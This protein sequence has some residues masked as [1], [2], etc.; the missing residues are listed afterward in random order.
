[1]CTAHLVV[2][3]SWLA[4]SLADMRDGELD[5]SVRLVEHRAVWE[6]EARELA[7]EISRVLGPETKVEHIGST[8][9]PGLPAKPVIDLLVGAS[10]DSLRIV[11]SRLESA[12]WQWL[13]EAGIPGRQYLRRRGRG[14]DANAHVVELGSP[15]WV[16]NLLLRD[17]LRSHHQAARR[18]A[19][20][21]RAA[22]SQAA[23]LLAYSE[24]KSDIVR[25]LLAEARHASTGDG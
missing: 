6:A 23:T 9:V 20:A 14:V 12:G 16:D 19:E 17:Y 18:Y 13:G 3:L 7:Q 22:A 25:D 4:P 10:L 21:K 24:L 15:L 2:M 11:S 1:M 5:E 8:A